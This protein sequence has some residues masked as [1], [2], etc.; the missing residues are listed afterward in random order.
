MPINLN[1]RKF[2]KLS[3]ISALAIGGGFT[4]GKLLGKS[5]NQH[6][7][8][9]C[10]LP[11]DDKLITEVIRVFAATVK[12]NSTPIINA[13]DDYKYLLQKLVLKHKQTSFSNSGS[14]SYSV[15]PL[16]KPVNSD[17]I[18]SDT[19]KSIYSLKNDFTDELMTIRSMLYGTEAKIFFTAVYKQSN[20]LSLMFSSNQKEIVIENKKGT[21]D[22]IPLNSTY[23][24]VK[25]DGPQGETE[26]EINNGL[27]K[28]TKST[29]RHK[30]C[31]KSQYAANVG[32]VIACAPNKVLIRIEIV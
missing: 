29:C 28:V 24:N 11:S 2:I 3:S 9:Y 25:V 32:D 20:I 19:N 16:N 4:A 10:F 13:D 7:S 12:S 14:V 31:E 15:K 23:K 26:I 5:G 22:K 27:V 1:R 6:Y 21:F 8:V 17:I 30:L 18:V